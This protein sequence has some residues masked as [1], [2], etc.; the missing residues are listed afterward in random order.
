MDRKRGICGCF[1]NILQLLLLWFTYTYTLIWNKHSFTH[2]FT[3]SFTHPLT[4]SS[5]KEHMGYEHLILRYMTHATRALMLRYSIWHS[6]LSYMLIPI[7]TKT[8]FYTELRIMSK[9]RLIA[10][11]ITTSLVVVWWILLIHKHKATLSSCKVIHNTSLMIIPVIPIFNV[12][13]TIG[14]FKLIKVHS[15]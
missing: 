2:P 9:L 14:I 4:N 5:K 1:Y 15:D 13:G 3:H 10:S 6:I 12:E 7:R 8:T 11:I